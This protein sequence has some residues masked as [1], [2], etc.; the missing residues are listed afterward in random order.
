MKPSRKSTKSGNA[1]RT[2]RPA[3]QV[4]RKSPNVIKSK[5]QCKLAGKATIMAV[6][7]TITVTEPS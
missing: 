6:F 1:Y 5:I 4:G 7:Q 3:V 2:G